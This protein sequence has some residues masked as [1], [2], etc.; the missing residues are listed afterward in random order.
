MKNHTLTKAQADRMG[1]KE[2]TIVQV[3]MKKYPEE[4]NHKNMA[5]DVFLDGR[6]IGG[7]LAL[8]E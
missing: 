5:K 6:R 4:T 2:G 7:T 8:D 1:Q 3:T